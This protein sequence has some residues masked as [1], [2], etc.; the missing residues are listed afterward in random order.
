MKITF[1]IPAYNTAQYLHPAVDSCLSQSYKN[2]EVIVV[3]DC[4]TDSTPEYLKW[5]EKQGH[6]NLKII[7]NEVNLGRS[8]SRNLGNNAATGDIIA[9]LDAD[10]ISAPKRAE[11]TVARFKAGSV[12][13]HGAA[14]RMD[15]VGRDLGMMESDIFNLEKSLE[16]LSVGIIHSTV[17]YSKEL[18]MKYPYL[19]G[20]ADKLGVDDFTIFLPMA[21]S[22]VKFDYIPSPLVA[23]RLNDF[24][25]TATR[26]K[27]KV[28]DFK[29]EFV[30]GLKVA[31]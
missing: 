31:A 29:T 7:R 12:F 30:K 9:V 6:A 25:V 13:V 8:A 19:S 3:D 15:P 16:L 21:M 18:A 20:E 28:V 5:L 23:Y 17:A 26:D 4:S 2:V 10:D 27:Q 22:G 11:L 1:I 24:G 14:H